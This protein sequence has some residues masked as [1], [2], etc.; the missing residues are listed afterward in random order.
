MLKEWM[1]RRVERVEVLMSG[2]EEKEKQLKCETAEELK[3]ERVEWLK[4]EKNK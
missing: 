3:K 4:V 1:S 2:R